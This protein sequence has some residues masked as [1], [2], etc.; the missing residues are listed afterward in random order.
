MMM[1]LPSARTPGVFPNPAAK[2]L[3]IPGWTIVAI[4]AR[5]FLVTGVRLL[6][7]SDGVVIAADKYGKTKTVLQMVY[8]FVFLFFAGAEHFVVAFTPD[9][10]HDYRR[11]L[12]YS[13]FIA[14]TMVAA[15]TAYSGVVFMRANWG[16]LHLGDS[17]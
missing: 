2:S 3:V 10:A 1:T 5:E 4:F 7:A 15:Y 16:Q 13:S 14:V 17:K 11:V 9:Y 6:A 12:E 8:V